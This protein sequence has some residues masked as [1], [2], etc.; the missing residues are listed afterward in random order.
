MH[1]HAK[2]EGLANARCLHALP[3]AAPE[4]RVKQNHVDCRVQ[5]VSGQLLEVDNDSIRRERHS[6][7]LSHA[8]HPGH[9]K[10]RILQIIIVNALDLMAEPDRCFGRPYAIR[11]EAESIAVECQCQSAITCQLILRRK[12]SAL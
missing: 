9:S 10:D 4:S 3:D 11:I 8:A 12:N 5:Y 1:S 2:L 6:H 7:L